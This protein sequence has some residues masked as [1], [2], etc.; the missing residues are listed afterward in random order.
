MKKVAAILVVVLLAG[1]SNAIADNFTVSTQNMSFAGTAVSP[2]PSQSYYIQWNGPYNGT[3]TVEVYQSRP[4]IKVS[5]NNSTFST[6]LATFNMVTGQFAFIYVRLETLVPLTL[7]G[8]GGSDCVRNRIEY[9]DASLGSTLTFYSFV[10]LNGSVPL[11]IQLAS[12]SIRPLNGSQTMLEWTTLSETNNFGFYV[13]KECN[14]VWNNVS[15]LIPGHGTTLSRNDY[16]YVDA[17]G[18]ANPFADTQYRLLQIDLDGTEHYTEPVALRTTDVALLNAPK[19]FSVDQNY[20]NP[21]NPSTTIRYGLPHA[22]AVHL[23]VFNTLGQHVAT[24][25]QEE[26]ESGYHE[27]KFDAST[28]PSGVYYYRLQAGDFVQS[29]RLVLLR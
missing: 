13:Q 26:Q 4:Y 17:S 29:R 21:F 8:F 11:P 2:S 3:V 1:G 14:G 5:R 16:S 25:V 9:F 27:V 7:E 12:F 20:P 22:S 19:D 24:L 6:T 15:Q 23:T 28:L 10:W 18:D